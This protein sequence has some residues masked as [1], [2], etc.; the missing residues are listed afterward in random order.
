VF[1]SRPSGS[2]LPIA[3]FPVASFDGFL[4]RPAGRFSKPFARLRNYAAQVALN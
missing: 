3:D 1:G 4:E 2:R